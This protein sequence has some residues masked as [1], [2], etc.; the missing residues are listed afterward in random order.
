[1]PV[2]DFR[3][4]SWDNVVFLWRSQCGV[5]KC[6]TAYGIF[7]ACKCS[8]E[9]SR[10]YRKNIQSPAITRCRIRGIF[11]H[12]IQNRRGW[13]HTWWLPGDSFGRFIRQE[14]PRLL[15]L[16]KWKQRYLDFY[17]IYSV[18]CLPQPKN[19]LTESQKMRGEAKK[20]TSVGQSYSCLS[21][22]LVW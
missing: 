15:V 4:L 17:E 10:P 8:L 16:E 2:L 18:L 19:F 9:F 11:C 7:Y 5:G 14:N 1:M 6:A 22:N 3:T 20:S 21:T 13:P 12:Q